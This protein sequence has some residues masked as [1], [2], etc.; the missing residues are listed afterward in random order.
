[1]IILDCTHVLYYHLLQFRERTYF[2]CL[3]QVSVNSSSK[4]WFTLSSQIVLKADQIR[5][6][7]MGYCNCCLVYDWCCVWSK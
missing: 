7:I 2:K 6:T 5:W 4:K 3:H 1:M